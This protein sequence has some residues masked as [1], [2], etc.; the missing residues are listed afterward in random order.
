MEN[1]S[2]LLVITFATLAS[3][4][5]FAT[6]HAD[7]GAETALL[8][9]G[10]GPSYSG[11]ADADA[12]AAAAALGSAVD[13]PHGSSSTSCCSAANR[14]KILIASLLALN[15][16]LAG[17]AISEGVVQSIS[18][19]GNESDSTSSLPVNPPFNDVR[20]IV[21]GGRNV[22]SSA[23][24]VGSSNLYWEKNAF[25]HP[26]LRLNTSNVSASF[27]YWDR[28]GKEGS[29]YNPPSKGLCHY[30]YKDEW[31]SK[32]CTPNGVFEPPVEW[33]I[34]ITNNSA[35]SLALGVIRAASPDA[36]DVRCLIPNM[37]GQPGGPPTYCRS[38]TDCDFFFSGNFYC[39]PQPEALGDTICTV[40]KSKHEKTK[41]EQSHE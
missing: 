21:L 25:F 14:V 13:E 8:A 20:H 5:I 24:Q 7:S 33:Q 12:R 31:Q 11:A 15:S 28:W 3:F 10:V 38:Q 39:V 32:S 30:Y 35:N 23:V 29:Q 37:H 40:I 6:D 19:C 16:A 18:S 34:P 2:L 1:K 22:S 36:C 9:A 26:Y 41:L 4:T 27:P 17:T